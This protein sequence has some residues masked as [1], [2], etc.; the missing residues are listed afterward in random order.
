M[1][2]NAQADFPE[3]RKLSLALLTINPCYNRIKPINKKITGPKAQ[4][5]VM[6]HSCRELRGRLRLTAAAAA[7]LACQGRVHVRNHFGPHCQVLCMQS[8]RWGC[9]GLS[10]QAQLPRSRITISCLEITTEKWKHLP[11]RNC[12]VSE[13][14]HR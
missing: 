11:N 5:S 13:S 9:A 14:P 6:S 10:K 7:P 1:V 4:P 3:V 12:L 8:V 2:L